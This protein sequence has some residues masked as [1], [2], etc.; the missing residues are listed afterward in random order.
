M[1]HIEAVYELAKAKIIL[2]DEPTIRYWANNLKDY[3]PEEVH[4]GVQFIIDS[5][6]SYV[7]LGLLTKAV[8]DVKLR[9]FKEEQNQNQKEE[10]SQWRENQGT[11]PAACRTAIDYLGIQNPTSKDRQRVVDAHRDEVAKHPPG[12][13]LRRLWEKAANTWEGSCHDN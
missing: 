3:T 6:Q 9:K 8:K 10:H 1:T 12:T 11:M 4:A 13:E 2:D 7:H 5:G